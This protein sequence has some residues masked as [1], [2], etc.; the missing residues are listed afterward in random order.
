MALHFAITFVTIQ[1]HYRFREFCV[2]WCDGAGLVRAGQRHPTEHT[3]YVEIAIHAYCVSRW[4]ISS[5]WSPIFDLHLSDSAAHGPRSQIVIMQLTRNICGLANRID[6][7]AHFA[8]SSKSPEAARRTCLEAAKTGMQLFNYVEPSWLRT[9][10]SSMVSAG[11]R[12]DVGDDVRLF[13]TTIGDLLHRL[14]VHQKAVAR[15][16]TQLSVWDGTAVLFQPF[17]DSLDTFYGIV[18]SDNDRICELL[19]DSDDDAS[20]MMAFADAFYGLTIAVAAIYSTPR[21][22]NDYRAEIAS[23]GA[24]IVLDASEFLQPLLAC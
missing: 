14:G 5:D 23:A 1:P 19:L 13:Q 3:D 22:L 15:L 18:E 16:G 2:Y 11:D 17:G 7:A 12:L 4:E 21:E 8:T 10:Y 24:M 9:A 20:N 6:L